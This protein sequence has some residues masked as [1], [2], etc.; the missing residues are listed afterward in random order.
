MTK[1]EG[2]VAVIT[3]GST[4]IGLATAKLFVEEGAHVYITGRRQRELDAAVRQIEKNVTGVQGDVVDVV[5]LDRLYATVKQQHGRI[6]ILFANAGVQSRTP[7]GE[8]TE[9]YF[10]T[11][12][13]INVK[14]LLF[15][16]Q[17]AMPLVQDGSSIILNSSAAAYKGIEGS[18]VY[19]A[20]KAAVRSFA[21][22]WSA[23]LK[24]RK[25][26]VNAVSP[27]PINTPLWKSVGETKEQIEQALAGLATMIPLGRL[28]D[29]DDVAKAALFLASDDSSFI[30]GAELFLDGGLGQV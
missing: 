14:G 11:V 22:T 18:T 20:S 4:G 27:G 28:G 1:L 2:K 13:N 19:S 30:T 8:I 17:K 5:D 6:D 15:T 25:I 9:A 29:P 26:R 12:F 10:D 24:T 3:G 7:L 16:V 23:E 21:R